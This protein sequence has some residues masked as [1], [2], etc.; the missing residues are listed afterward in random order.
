MTDPGDAGT[1]QPTTDDVLGA[2]DD[3]TCRCILGE[4]AREPLSA[5]E[6]AEACGVSSSTAYRKIQLLA[7]AGLLTRST[8]VR[9]DGNHA[10]QYERSFAAVVVYP[11]TD[12]LDV[13]VLAEDRNDEGDTWPHHGSTGLSALEERG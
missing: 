3:E 11:G 10:S 2:L 5:S 6:I 8:R 12:G 9:S 4:T 13:S 1:T 7:G